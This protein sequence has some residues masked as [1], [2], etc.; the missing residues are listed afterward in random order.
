MVEASFGDLRRLADWLASSTNIAWPPWLPRVL[1]R[2]GPTAVPALGR[3]LRNVEPRRRDAARRALAAV[4]AVHRDRVVAELHAIAGEHVPGLDDA[5]AC[6][7]G[8]LAELGERGEARFADPPAIRRRSA[9]ALAGQLDT[10]A[11]IAGVVDL[12]LQR[13]DDDEIADMV[14]AMAEVASAA[15]ARVAAEIG[16]RLDASADLQARVAP[17]ATAAVPPLRRDR[18]ARASVLVDAAARLVVVASRRHGKRSRRWAVLIGASG[19]IDG[20]E[21]VESDGPEADT[22]PLIDELSARG[23]RVATTDTDHARAIVA[24]AARLT[25]SERPDA[26]AAGYYL[27]RDLL[28]LGDAHL[29]GRPRVAVVAATL[30]RAVELLATDHAD[31]AYALL[32]RCDASDPEVAAATAA[33]LVAQGRHADA[34]AHLVRACDGDREWPLHHWNLAA[35]LHAT[36]DVDG[37]GGALRAFLATSETTT[38]LDADPDQPARVALARRL[39]AERERTARLGVKGKRRRRPRRAARRGVVTPA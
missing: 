24:A 8:L 4:A 39:V 13:L 6:A 1:D 16:C 29:A 28:E 33:C 25:A 21:H 26:L 23:Y 11:E 22:A 10:A 18:A 20:C 15:A 36:G 19:A 3:A 9:L 32:A 38:A 17:A 30:G 37:C 2:L 31:R 12:M 27:G 35:A 7:V 14:D 34:I 5:K